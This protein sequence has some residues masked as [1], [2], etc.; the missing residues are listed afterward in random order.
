M[1]QVS[2]PILTTTQVDHRLLE[3]L[4]MFMENYREMPQYQRDI[5]FDVI[6]HIV[7]KP[8]P[9]ETEYLKEKKK[10]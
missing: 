6:Q 8:S 1:T 3:M 5:M 9:I 4:R 2:E 7:K 10:K